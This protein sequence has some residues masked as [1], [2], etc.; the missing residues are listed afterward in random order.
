MPLSEETENAVLKLF[1]EKGEWTAQK[2]YLGLSTIAPASLKKTT[3]AKEFG[4]KE[5][6]EA[7]GWARKEIDTFEWTKELGEGTEAEA[8]YRKWKNKNAFTMP[9]VS[10]GEYKLETFAVLVKAKQTEDETSSKGIWVFGKLKEAVTINA[11]T[12]E[13]KFAAGALEIEAL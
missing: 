9:L 5:P 4:E 11:S 8:K 2:G 13:I 10:A 6:A 1:L 12:T 7:N 3:T